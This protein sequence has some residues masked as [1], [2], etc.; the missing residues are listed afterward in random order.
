M[1]IPSDCLPFLLPRCLSLLPDLLWDE[2]PFDTKKEKKSLFPWVASGRLA[3]HPSYSRVAEKDF[4]SCHT[5][6]QRPLLSYCVPETFSMSSFVMQKVICL[7][8]DPEKLPSKSQAFLGERSPGTWHGTAHKVKRKTQGES[9]WWPLNRQESHS[10]KENWLMQKDYQRKGQRG[11]LWHLKGC[12]I[13]CGKLCGETDMGKA[14]RH[15][16]PSSSGRTSDGLRLNK[17]QW[18]QE[19]GLACYFTWDWYIVGTKL[20]DSPKLMGKCLTV[21]GKKWFGECSPVLVEEEGERM[22]GNWG[23]EAVVE[24]RE[25][26]L[27]PWEEVLGVL[28]EIHSALVCVIPYMLSVLWLGRNERTK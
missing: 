26:D 16:G 19:H 2:L 1:G 21:W 14:N 9:G 11:D 15:E 10:G 23:S 22:L 4:L 13:H 6:L 27:K 3:C 25:R 17:P 24:A 7:F 18:G 5:C 28:S 8:N 12:S 20:R